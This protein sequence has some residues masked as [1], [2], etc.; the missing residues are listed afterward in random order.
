MHEDSFA[1]RPDN[2]S[3]ITSQTTKQRNKEKNKK[4]KK[5]KE[6]ERKNREQGLV[7]MVADQTITPS[8]GESEGTESQT[9]KAV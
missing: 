6:K 8:T 2:N 1:V 5:K 9:D 4:T 7:Q 3:T